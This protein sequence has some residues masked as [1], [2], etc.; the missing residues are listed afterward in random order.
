[1]LLQRRKMPRVIQSMLSVDDDV[2]LGA[3]D[4][5]AIAI[6][7]CRGA[8]KKDINV[9]FDMLRQQ[10]KAVPVGGIVPHTQLIIRSAPY[11]CTNINNLFDG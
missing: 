11:R 7:T 8:A 4:Q 10:S 5:A 2:W 3:R 9:N 6:W 1:M